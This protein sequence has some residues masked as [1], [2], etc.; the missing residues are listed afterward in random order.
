M[1]SLHTEVTYS[2]EHIMNSP[3]RI[4]TFFLASMVFATAAFAGTDINK[5]VAP[6]GHVTLTDEV[7]PAGNDTVPVSFG[8]Q[9]PLTKM[10]ARTA[11]M[12]RNTPPSRGLA[13]DVAML[14][15]ARANL[16]QF[17]AASQ[18]L[19]SQRLAGLP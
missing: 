17:D 8:V 13:L 15:T 10:S 19:R 5:C 12:A 16:Q 14:K 11:A 1:E 6:D 18:A 9:A 4:R 3:A 2:L 7:C